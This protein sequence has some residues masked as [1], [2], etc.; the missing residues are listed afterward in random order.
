MG[1][2]EMA[3]TEGTRTRF[4]T[5]NPPKVDFNHLTRT[6][7]PLVVASVPSENLL[8]CGAKL[9]V[10]TCFEAGFDAILLESAC[11]ADITAFSGC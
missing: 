7:T 9:F 4:L 1:T 2:V 8:A 11:L 5:L 3:F 6:Q 10:H